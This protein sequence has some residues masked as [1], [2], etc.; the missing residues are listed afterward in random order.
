MQQTAKPFTSIWIVVVAVQAGSGE[1]TAPIS[2]VASDLEGHQF[3][4]GTPK[5]LSVRFPPYP[6]GPRA[7]VVTFGACDML[8]VHLAL[9]WRLPERIVDLMIEFRTLTNGKGGLA[10]GGLAGA[11][12]WL[13]CSTAGAFAVGNQAHCMRQR[14]DAVTR[15]FLAMRNT[16]PLGHALLR[17]R[18]LTAVARIEAVGLPSDQRAIEQLREKWVPIKRRVMQLIDAEFGVYPDGRFDAATFE[19]WLGRRSIAWPRLLSRQLDLGD[20]AFRQMAR[21]HPEIRPLKATAFT[22]LRRKWNWLAAPAAE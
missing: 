19:T 15:L 3:E 22:H 4:I 16:L 21:L 17:G 12:L 7:L 8:G 20:D 5:L 11:L 2:V 9:G 13:G 10:V 6:T 1:A 18:Y 14:L